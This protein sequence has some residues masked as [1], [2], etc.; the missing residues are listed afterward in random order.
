MPPDGASWFACVGV[1][2]GLISCEIMVLYDDDDDAQTQEKVT[3][4]AP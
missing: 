1:L 2:G 4:T 3:L